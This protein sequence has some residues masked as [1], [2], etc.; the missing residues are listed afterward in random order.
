MAWKSV[1]R[2][3]INRT[4]GL[5]SLKCITHISLIIS[6]SLPPPP[7]PVSFLIPY[8]SP[9]RTE[10]TTEDTSRNH[11]CLPQGQHS[12]GKH[13]KKVWLSPP[14]DSLPLPSILHRNRKG[15]VEKDTEGSI[16]EWDCF[17]EWFDI[18]CW[19]KT[20]HQQYLPF[21]SLIYVYCM[22]SV[23]N[24]NIFSCGW[25]FRSKTI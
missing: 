22:L 25:L 7:P 15:S 24:T 2:H 5:Q 1:V 11:T 10:N 12:L 14:F 17:Y 19:M 20:V 18:Q 21:S 9:A 3:S 4:Q 13:L 8:T 16:P 6:T 23:L